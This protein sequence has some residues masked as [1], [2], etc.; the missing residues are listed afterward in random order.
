MLSTV[1]L[2]QRTA[3]GSKAHLGW[4]FMCLLCITY[5]FSIFGVWFVHSLLLDDDMLHDNAVKL[6]SDCDAA[7]NG[8]ESP[9]SSTSSSAGASH[10]P[11]L[12]PPGQQRRGGV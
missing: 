2:F 5:F 1:Q 10:S 12:G 6:Y 11:T 9:S 3:P 8:R 4:A 7:G